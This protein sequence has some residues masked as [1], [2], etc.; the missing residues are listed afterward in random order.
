[1]RTFQ[2]HSVFAIFIN[3]HCQL[4]CVLDSDSDTIVLGIWGLSSRTLLRLGPEIN[5]IF[6]EDFFVA[7]IYPCSL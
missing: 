4:N 5:M 7:R 6:I 1:M 2:G 3:G